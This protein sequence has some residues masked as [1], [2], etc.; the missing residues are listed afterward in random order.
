VIYV[1]WKIVSYRKQYNL[2]KRKFMVDRQQYQ[3]NDKSMNI[4]NN[5]TH[6]IGN[7]GLCSEHAHIC[8]GYQTG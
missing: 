3:E 2:D 4:N 5:K 8:G 1:Y 6:D 7:P